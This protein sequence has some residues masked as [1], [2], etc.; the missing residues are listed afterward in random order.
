MRRRRRDAGR[1]LDPRAG[2][3]QWFVVGAPVPGSTASA[4]GA[5]AHNVGAIRAVDRYFDADAFL[6][7]AG[8]VYERA[9]AAWRD[10]NVELLRPVMAEQV[11]DRY[12]QFLLTVSTL[13]LG[14]ELMASA[15]TTA[16]LAGADLDAASQSVLTSFAVTTSG[17][18]L[19]VLDERFRRWQERWLFQRPPGSRTHASGAVAV[20]LVC[21]GPASPDESGECPYCHADIT[22]RTAGWL[23]TQVATTM[24]SA[25]KIGNRPGAATAATPLQPPRAT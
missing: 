16:S 13:A 17:P 24:P 9:T 8:S 14:R 11:W 2:T 6:A 21:G 25:P 5:V 12:A 20:C 1:D 23:V 7:W 18:R 22:T 3:A 4:D 10:K 19:S 15:K